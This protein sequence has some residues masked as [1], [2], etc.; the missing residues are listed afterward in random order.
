MIR[1]IDPTRLVILLTGGPTDFWF[2]KMKPNCSLIVDVYGRDDLRNEARV[3]PF[4]L[5]AS[6]ADL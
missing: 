6:K 3:H 4:G 1:N 2:D 5:D